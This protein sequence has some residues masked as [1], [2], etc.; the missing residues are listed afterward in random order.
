MPAKTLMN[1]MELK[2]I[3]KARYLNILTVNS[4][5]TSC[6]H[7]YVLSAREKTFHPMSF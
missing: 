4:S 3:I 5:R 6:P 1:R 2:Q 7:S